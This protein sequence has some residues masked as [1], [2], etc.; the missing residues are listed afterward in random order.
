MMFFI[1]TKFVNTKFTV[2][3]SDRDRW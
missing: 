1:Q 2:S 3:R